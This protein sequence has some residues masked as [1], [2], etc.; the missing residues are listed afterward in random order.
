MHV[1]II[2]VDNRTWVTNPFTRQWQEL[3]NT[4][5][6]DFAN[7]AALISGAACP[8]S[9]ARQLEDGGKLD[10]VD[11]QVVTGKIESG[12]LRQALGIAEPGHVLTVQAWIGVDDMLP[13]RVRVSGP[14]TDTESPDVVRQVDVS[15]YDQPVEIMPPE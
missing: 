15:R 1:Q 3:P 11:T 6:R 8:R 13:R 14:L 4:N 7:P 9:R 2:G 12:A 5:I 10:G